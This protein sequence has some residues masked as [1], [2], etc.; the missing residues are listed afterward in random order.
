MN[1]FAPQLDP[2][3]IVLKINQTF[4]FDKS[5]ANNWKCNP[6]LKKIISVFFLSIFPLLLDFG[7]ILCLFL[8]TVV[9]KSWKGCSWNFSLNYLLLIKSCFC[10][11]PN[12]IKTSSLGKISIQKFCSIWDIIQKYHLTKLSIFLPW[13][14]SL[15]SLVI[16]KLWR[17]V[18]SR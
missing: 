17:T 16:A 8:S 5:S 13:M 14:T 10:K 3:I 18:T 11:S 2:Q 7:P 1:Q 12:N 4:F 15:I 9:K 6:N